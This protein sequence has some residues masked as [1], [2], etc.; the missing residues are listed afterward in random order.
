MATTPRLILAEDDDFLR[1]LLQ[2]QCESMGALVAPA[3]DG[4]EAVSLALSY[5]YD[6]LL[7]DI[8]M[9]KCDGIQAMTLLRQLGYDRPIVAMSSDAVTAEGF[10]SVLKKPLNEQDLQQLL[11]QETHHPAVELVVSDDLLQEFLQGL[12]LTQQQLEEARQASDWPELQRL[13]HKLKGSAGSFGFPQLSNA[14]D[15][16]QRAIQQSQTEARLDVAFRQ[17]VQQVQE[18][19]HE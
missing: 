4:E 8:N 16:L 2:M 7:L 9:P 15:Q 10:S 6:I 19:S 18:A 11:H 17:L 1:Q 13:S 14:A 12:V 3:C 5:E